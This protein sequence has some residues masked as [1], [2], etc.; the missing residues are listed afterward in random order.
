MPSFET[1]DGLSL[2]Y[3]DDGQ[4]QPVLCLPGLTRNHRD[5]DPVMPHLSDVRVIRL[6]ARGRGGSAY[7]PNHANYNLHRET[8][9]VIELLD[10]L[11]LPDTTILGTSRGGLAAML[12]AMLAPERLRGA[13]LNDVGPEIASDGL[14]RI[15]DY[16]GITPKS[17]N[18]DDAAAAMKHVFGA[19]FPDVSLAFWREQAAAQYEETPQ[20]LRLRYDPQLRLALLDQASAGPTPDLWPLF[21]AVAARPLG[22]IRGANSDLLSEGTAAEMQ[23]RAPHMH[24]ANIPNRA[25][26]PFLNEAGSL[27]VIG[28]V[29]KDTA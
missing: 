19:H 27:D 7:D 16:V 4:G 23:R 25:H 26:V 2:Y 6:D 14:T 1:S 3:T 11:S 24:F 12:L 15:M 9:D 28:A 13:I 5:F 18:Y 22:L 17:A 8:L 20:G 21:D 29:L 10:H